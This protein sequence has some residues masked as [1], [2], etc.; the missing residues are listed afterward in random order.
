M[1]YSGITKEHGLLNT[2]IYKY[3]T[4]NN[5]AVDEDTDSFELAKAIENIHH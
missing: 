2:Q 5:K 3:L 4:K 1:I